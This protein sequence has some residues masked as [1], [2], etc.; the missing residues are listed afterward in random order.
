MSNVLPHYEVH[1]R[2]AN[3]WT[4]QRVCDD[5]KSAIESAENLLKELSLKAV[6][7]LEVSCN[8]DD[9]V[10]HDKEI[11]YDGEKIAAS[12][13]PAVDL[14]KPVCQKISDFY[15]PEARR[16]IATLLRK[17]MGGWKI[18]PLELLYHAEHLQ[19]L[20]DTGQI[21]Q[22]AVQRVAVSQIQKTGQKVN[23]RVLDL[24]KLTGEILQELKVQ[25]HGN[26]F[27][28]LEN[29]D[30][31]ELLQKAK[32]TEAPNVAFIA[33]FCRYLKDVPS[34]EHKF[35]KILDLLDCNDD[36]EIILY[37]D[38]FLGDFFV[39]S[40]NIKQLVGESDNLGEGV[41]RLIDL[42]RG[43]VTLT[44]DS[45]KALGRVNELI[46]SKLL[47]ET[48]K[49][50]VLKVKST[51]NGNASFVKGQPFQSIMYHK[52]ILSRL[53]LNGEKYIGGQECVDALTERCTRMTGSASIEEFLSGLDHPLDRI[54][55]FLELTKGMVG[56]VNMRT[57]ANYILP[58]LESSYNVTM[59]VEEA[60]DDL[61]TLKKMSIL[62][63]KLRQSELQFFFQQRIAEHLDQIGMEIFT[64]KNV[65]DQLEE[66]SDDK[67]Q[68]GFTLLHMVS[69]GAV[70]RP[71]VMDTVRVF[72]KRTIMSADFMGEL[73]TKA[74]GGNAD[75]LKE[76]YLLLKNTR[77]D[78]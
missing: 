18:T 1:G 44:A 59:I 3:A 29:E 49:S 73:E 55:R 34:L 51:L 17:P 33:A 60:T 77:L 76:F 26:D 58:I 62:Q 54:E 70:P 31:S 64:R 21:L 41:L 10:F 40:E 57:I 23:Q 11:F 74:K 27:L 78:K 66:R 71:H 19:K 24:Y 67:L 35:E 20:N 65:E 75:L 28:E 13:V 63:Q 16:A 50:L 72:A 69:E 37:L 7:V 5:K 8:G 36:P 45:H 52:R 47:P 15:L 6:K 38:Q 22:G 61:A 25:R 46:G 43:T 68:L 42:I 14:I 30:L 12:N 53:S 4:V 9:P 39:F 48:Q 32:L 2:Q 56:D